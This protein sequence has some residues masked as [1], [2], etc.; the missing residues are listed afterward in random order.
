MPRFLTTID[1]DK[2]TLYSLSSMHTTQLQNAR[3][4][5]DGLSVGDA[6]GEALSYRFYE[7]R[8]CI[9]D[10][11]DSGAS[12]CYTDDTEMACAI[13]D[14]LSQ[15]KSIDEDHLA[16]LFAKRYKKDPDRGYGKMARK[17]LQD[18]SVGVPWRESS[19]RAFGGG[20]FGNGAAMR[21]APLG[22]YFFDDMDKLTIIARRS[23]RVTHFHEEGI[24]GAIAVAVASAAASQ[25]RGM[26]VDKVREFVSELVVDHTPQGRTASN[27]NHALNM[28]FSVDPIKVARDVGNGSEISSQDTV[29]FCIWNACR[30][31][32]NYR[33][34][35]LSTIEVGGDCDTNCAIVGGIVSAHTG[36]QGIPPKWLELR[37]PI[38]TA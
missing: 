36:I 32:E 27:I 16:W 21:V 38:S 28:G 13:Y 31:L 35:L 34:A 20:S 33:E 22:G 6:I 18:I 37:E 11:E 10:L 14:S 19:S 29:P 25:C 26:P 3:E 4:I 5:L 9:E 12:L 8:Q 23:A 24:A 17:I 1:T 7:A 2:P 15:L 30:S